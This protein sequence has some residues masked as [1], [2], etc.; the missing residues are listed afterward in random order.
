M[1]NTLIAVFAL[2]LSAGAAQAQPGYGMPSEYP[3]YGVY[4]PGTSRALSYGVTPMSYYGWYRPYSAG[5]AVPPSGYR[6]TDT[7]RAP[8]VSVYEPRTLSG[9]FWRR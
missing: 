8:G 1:R 9:R 7:Y 3:G 4:A 6:S 5:P 2:T